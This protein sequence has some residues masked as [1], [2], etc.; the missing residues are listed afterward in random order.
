MTTGYLIHFYRVF[1]IRYLLLETQNIP[2]NIS[3]LSQMH[4]ILCKPKHS[5]FSL[6]TNNSG[7]QE[8]RRL[9]SLL[10]QLPDA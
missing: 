3:F 2:Q 4:Y 5:F 10:S 9:L 8:A 1:K 6:V 7:H